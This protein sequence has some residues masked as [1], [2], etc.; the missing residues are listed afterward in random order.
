VNEPTPPRKSILTDASNLGLSRLLEPVDEEIVW[1][2]DDFPALFEHLLGARIG[3]EL[4]DPT[5][6]TRHETIQHCLVSP[7]REE[8]LL[9]AIKKYAVANMSDP[10]GSLPKP[11]AKALFL[12]SIASSRLAGFRGFSRLSDVEFQQGGHWCLAQ[13]W[14]PASVRELVRDALRHSS[15]EPGRVHP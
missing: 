7:Q 4:D 13:T 3:L 15:N 10:G 11:L 6:A 9:L 14:V 1:C 8:G 2:E 12:A 5:L